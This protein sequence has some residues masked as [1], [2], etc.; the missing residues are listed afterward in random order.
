M[1]RTAKV[2]VGDKIGVFDGEQFTSESPGLA[3]ILNSALALY[4]QS[5]PSALVGDDPRYWSDSLAQMMAAI[6]VYSAG[7]VVQIDPPEPI[8]PP[9]GAVY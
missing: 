4:R 1:A 2:K 6:A 3:V 8:E 7:E 9:E 5:G